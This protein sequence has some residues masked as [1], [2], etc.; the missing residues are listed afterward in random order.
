MKLLL[1]AKPWRGGLARYLRAALDALLPGAVTWLPTYPT[2]F[3]EKIVYRRDRAA[4]RKKLAERISESDYDAAIFINHVPGFESLPA[5]DG[6]V[7]W[8]TD[9]PRPVVPHSSPYRRIFITDPGYRE[10]VAPALGERF[11]GVLSFAYLPSVHSPADAAADRGGFCFIANRDPKR[12]PYIR[13]L[14]SAQKDIRVYGNYF[15]LHPLCWRYPGRFRPA[16]ANQ[17]MADVYARHL[18][19]INIHARVV[20]GGTN[21]RTFECAG[22][23]IAQV[24]ERLPG[25]ET[26]FSPGEDLLTFETIDELVEQMARLESDPGFA[27]SLAVSAAR[28][29]LAR[30]T[31]FHRARA[32]LDDVIDISAKR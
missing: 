31:Y 28:R 13:A 24:V 20:K 18:G 2:T 12:D 10:E 25:L 7:L 3:S 5:N 16:V 23:G 22:Y 4:W 32:L 17:R 11:C 6:H 19:S 14:C 21:M 30:H 8:I 1:V 26:L 29:A 9:D 15:P 27:R